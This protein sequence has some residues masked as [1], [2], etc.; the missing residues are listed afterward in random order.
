MLRIE[1][2]KARLIEQ[3]SQ[4]K[5]KKKTTKTKL[6]LSEIDYSKYSYN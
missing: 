6:G 2:Q 4:R 5:N 1:Y 3:I